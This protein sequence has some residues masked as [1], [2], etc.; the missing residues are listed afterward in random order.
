MAKAG[1]KLQPGIKVDNA[2]AAEMAKIACA[3]KAL[4]MYATMVLEKE[5]CPEELQKLVEEGNVAINKIFIEE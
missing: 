1:W 2:T 4:S 3:L 5:D